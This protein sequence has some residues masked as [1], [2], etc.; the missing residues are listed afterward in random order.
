MSGK[1]NRREDLVTCLQRNARISL[2][3]DAGSPFWLIQPW[4]NL[5]QKEREALLL[6]FMSVN[7]TLCQIVHKIK[8]KYTGVAVSKLAME[9]K[10]LELVG[11]HEVCYSF[12]AKQFLWGLCEQNEKAEFGFTE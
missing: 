3:L 1:N 9:R 12:T 5:A 8:H 4:L 10:A 11:C 6:G 7:V 2:P